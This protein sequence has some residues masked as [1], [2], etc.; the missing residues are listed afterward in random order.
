MKANDF[1]DNPVGGIP[2]RVPLPSLP[3][4]TTLTIDLEEDTPSPHLTSILCSI[5]SAPAL[6]S[7][8]VGFPLWDLVGTLPLAG[9]WADVDGWLSRI[10]KHNEIKGSLS[11]T[12]KL[13]PEGKSVW[14]GFLQGFGACGGKIRTSDTW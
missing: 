4:L 12:L 11:L 2:P 8:A 6:T 7:V 3:T 9:P 14:E 5:G 13:W 10:V 1:P